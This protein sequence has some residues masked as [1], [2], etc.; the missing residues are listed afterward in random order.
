MG[1]VSPDGPDFILDSQFMLLMNP[2]TYLHRARNPDR[3]EPDEELMRIFARVGER[4]ARIPIKALQT[5][6]T[7]GYHR[8]HS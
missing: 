7:A 4:A 5:L 3:K 1:H 8:I 6:M 2:K